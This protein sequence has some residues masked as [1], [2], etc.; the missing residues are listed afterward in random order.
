[1]FAPENGAIFSKMNRIK[2]FVEW[3]L[4]GV[5]SRMGERMGIGSGVIR[6]Y[7][8][9]ISF[10]TLGSPVIFYFIAAFWINWKQHFFSNWRNPIRE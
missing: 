4:F 10:F 1:L 5:C 8:I 3:Q 6:K 2:D 7:F 9:Y